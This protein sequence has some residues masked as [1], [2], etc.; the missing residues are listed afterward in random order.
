M[1]AFRPEQLNKKIRPSKFFE[2]F[3]QQKGPGGVTRATVLEIQKSLKTFFLDLAHGAVAQEK[4][5]DF[6]IG[7]P[8][9]VEE[10]LKECYNQMNE[11][12]IILRSMD[13]AHSTSNPVSNWPQFAELYKRYNMK[14]QTYGVIYNGLLAFQ[15][16]KDIAHLVGISTRLGSNMMRGSKQTLLL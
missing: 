10:A 4:Y 3:I 8:R 2:N 13:A 16:T 5:M 6:L 15:N 9:I 12:T 14:G 7:D 11:C 1:R